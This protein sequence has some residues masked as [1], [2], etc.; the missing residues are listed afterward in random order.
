MIQ[1]GSVLK[2]VDN[3]GALFAECIH[4]Y[5][6]F[7]QRHVGV[8]KV[9]MVAV[10]TVVPNS[11]IKKGEKYLAVIVR[12]ISKVGRSDGSFINASE[13]GIVLIDKQNE[14]LAT[15]VFGPVFKELRKSG[16]FLKIISLAS[17]VI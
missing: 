5:G 14:M 12:T 4:V 15:R 2:V 17:E 1:A 10:K 9:I 3:S 13:N 16:F 8:G 7:K 6:G 11:K